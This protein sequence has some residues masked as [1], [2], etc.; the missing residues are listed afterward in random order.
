MTPERRETMKRMF[1]GTLRP[2]VFGS[3]EA[4]TCH[5]TGATVGD[6]GAKI[7]HL[8]P[9]QGQPPGSPRLVLVHT[10]DPKI[11]PPSGTVNAHHVPHVAPVGR[12][13]VVATPAL[14]KD[15]ALEEARASQP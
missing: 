13:P 11:R 6:P 15:P 12:L 8:A 5:V 7:E 14:G 4:K 2:A 3:D 10:P 9:G 1:R